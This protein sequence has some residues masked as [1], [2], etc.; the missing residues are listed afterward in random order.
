MTTDL[1]QLA[2]EHGPNLIAGAA[3]LAAILPRSSDP[4]SP[5]TALRKLIDL[6]GM[7]WG[8]A[9]NPPAELKTQAQLAAVLRQ[10]AQLLEA[11]GQVEDR[12]RRPLAVP[13]ATA[14][15]DGLVELE[16][17]TGP[18]PPRKPRW[19]DGRGQSRRR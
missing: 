2:T 6:V 9:G 17:E 11:G 8:H 4:S 19:K 5:W 3:A 14:P 7:N 15:Q 1:L 10:A 16:R 12:Q 13:P 18:R